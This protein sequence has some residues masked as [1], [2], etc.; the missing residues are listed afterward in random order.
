MIRK[1]L[2]FG[3]ADSIGRGLNW[4][5]LIVLPIFL[6]PISYGHIALLIATEVLGSSVVL[7]GQDRAILRFASESE[8]DKRALAAQITLGWIVLAL[9][10]TAVAISV[11]ILTRSI[12][13]LPIHEPID[14]VSLWVVIC[15][16][17]FLRL[18]WTA[19]ATQGDSARFFFVR[20]GYQAARVVPIVLIAAQSN[21]ELIGWYLRTSAIVCVGFC[22]EAI[23]SIIRGWGDLP[24]LS[25]CAKYW[26]F[27]APFVVHTASQSILS[28]GDRYL[29]LYFL[30]A[31]AVGAYSF[32]YSIGSA[33]TFLYSGI[34]VYFEPLLY[35]VANDTTRREK[36]L[37][38]FTLAAICGSS[39]MAAMLNY[40]A[41]EYQLH[42]AKQYA[43]SSLALVP[44]IL[45]AHIFNILYL[46][47][48][49]RLVCFQRTSPIASSSSIFAGANLL[50]NWVLIPPL[51]LAGAAYVTV[52]SYLGQSIY[53]FAAS[54]R[55]GGMTLHR[56]RGKGTLLMC[57]VLLAGI[58]IL[59]G[60]G[61]LLTT[62]LFAVV[63]SIAA[64]GFVRQFGIAAL[65]NR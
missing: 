19:L 43:N 22:F 29:V 14:I 26:R 52:T 13:E 54:L 41:Y 3:V 28:Y 47:S 16:A 44:I 59:R 32:A 10:T 23:F 48:N 35:S 20:V 31:E 8:S 58:V 37:G 6:D 63:A 12:A 55:A 62:V 39:T 15:S 61:V 5:L 33:I 9:I 36:L 38:G 42:L 18:Y 45:V 24:S 53:L 60:S 17:A 7:Y 25:L 2:A 64:I 11:Y 27:G 21:G 50:L 4:L 34:T 51:Q 40:A 57:G 1:L 46:Q 30:G 65:G 49:Y 56:V